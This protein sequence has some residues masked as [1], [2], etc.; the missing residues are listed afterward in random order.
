[1]QIGKKIFSASAASLI[2]FSSLATTAFAD[3][4]LSITGNGSDSTNV[5]TINNASTS[6]VVQDNAANITN[7]VDSS[8]TTGGNSSSGNTGGDVSLTTGDAT[9][10][11]TVTTAVNGNVAN[12]DCCNSGDTDVTI[13][14]NGSDS[15]N[16]TYLNQGS[17]NSVFQ[18]NDAYVYNSLYNN[19]DSGGNKAKDNTGGDVMVVSGAATST[20]DVSTLAN[21]NLVSMG[22]GGSAGSLAINIMGNG[23]DSVNK[24]KLAMGSDATVVQDNNA[25]IYNSIYANANT[26]WNKAKD[27]TG[28]DVL[29]MT[30]D[31]IA[32][33]TVD[34]LANFNWANLDCG[35]VLDDV[36]ATISGNGADSYNKIKANLGG[37][38]Q[39]FQGNCSYENS[40]ELWLYQDCGIDNIVYAYPASGHNYSRDNTGVG[41]SM[42]DLTTGDSDS[43]V[44]V[45]TFANANIVGP[46]PLAS[47]PA[48]GFD[49][50][51][52]L[53][54]LHMV[55]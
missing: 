36:T 6:T 45:S 2:M 10:D 16:S 43:I 40:L 29:V 13:S 52:I 47:I 48:L 41:G 11:T 21:A 53:G 25:D 15:R 33:V 7:Y 55:S 8:S 49:L 37:D 14:G 18:S 22:G 38:S 34:N 17:S 20:T 27:N 54:W 9:S 50:S 26:G 5:T 4:T 46:L 31:A 19:T 32:D 24:V 3:T 51:L 12:T 23:A 42:F 1:M 39:I 30:G 35:C 44:G 28:G